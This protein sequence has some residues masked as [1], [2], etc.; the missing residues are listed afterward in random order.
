MV[1]YNSALGG[2]PWESERDNIKK[3]VIEEGVT[4]IGYD[5]FMNC[6]SLLSVTIPSS[7]TSIGDDA[8]W[9]CTSLP[10]VTIPSSVTSIGKEAFWSCSSFSMGRCLLVSGGVP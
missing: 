9:F 6:Q 3:V 8:F 2:M 7:V 5:A 10:S 4:S 1:D